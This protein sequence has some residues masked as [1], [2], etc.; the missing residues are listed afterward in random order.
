MDAAVEHYSGD[1]FAPLYGLSRVRLVKVDQQL[2]QYR[3]A[4]SI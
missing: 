2:D 4:Y 1:C 3:R